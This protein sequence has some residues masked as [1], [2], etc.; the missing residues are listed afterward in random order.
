ME[1][2]ADFVS[3]SLISWGREHG[4]DKLVEDL[5]RLVDDYRVN[6]RE[7][8]GRRRE[9]KWMELREWWTQAREPG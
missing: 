4:Y 2:G 6:H 8:H 3:P 9:A 1:P 5:W 7:G